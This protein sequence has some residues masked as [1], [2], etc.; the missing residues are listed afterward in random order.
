MK[1]ALAILL[2][3]D[4]ESDAELVARAIKGGQVPCRL[5]VAHSGL[6]ALDYLHQRGG[7]SE[8]ATPDLILLDINMAGMDGGQLLKNMKRDDDLR[9]IPTVMLTRSAGRED[10]LDCYANGVN[11]YVVKPFD[12]HKF[13]DVVRQV[14][15]F[16][17]AVSVLPSRLSLMR[18]YR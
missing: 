9:L 7:F 1:K 16:W 14:V 11:C 10:V 12:A 5:S 4:D 17:S 18:A 6:Q 15:A 2:V 3:E 8:A 13:T